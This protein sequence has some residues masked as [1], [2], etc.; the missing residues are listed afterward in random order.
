M[1]KIS[2]K[3][4]IKNYYIASYNSSDFVHG[5]PYPAQEF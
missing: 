3:N 5:D 1:I 4:N 2:I